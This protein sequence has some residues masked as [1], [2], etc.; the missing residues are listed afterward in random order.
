MKIIDRTSFTEVGGELGDQER[1]T[2]ER[3]DMKLGRFNY[4]RIDEI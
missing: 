3:I 4:R 1:P 2:L